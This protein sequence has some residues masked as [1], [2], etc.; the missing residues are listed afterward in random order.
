MSKEKVSILSIVVNV[1]LATSKIAV[2]VTTAST[3]IV[4]EGF[5]SLVDIFASAINF[6]GIKVARKPSDE[7][8]PYGHEK[9]EILSALVITLILFGTGAGIIYESYRQFLEPAPATLSAMAFGV[10]IVSAVANGI[11]A[12]VKI[13]CGQ[14][15]NSLSLISDGFHSRVDV[16]TSVAVIGGLAL[17]SYWLYADPLFALLVGI[18]IIKE[19]FSLGR[20]AV[21]SLLDVSAGQEVEDAVHSVAAQQNI[22]ISELKTQKRG[23]SITANLE[24][25]LPRDLK[26]DDA[27]HT[28][29]RLRESLLSQVDNLKYVAIQIRSHDITTSFYKPSY[30]RGFGWQHKGRFQDGVKSAAGKGPGGECRCPQCDYKT[31]HEP[32]VPCANSKCPKCDIALERS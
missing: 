1:L 7:K 25:S 23:S 3:L 19:S 30:G 5:H 14:R 22:D 15:E 28:A 21:D 2:G 12:R 17:S 29:D 8:H 6:I 4:A 20:E 32:G 16:Y 18:Y 13:S 10:M 11:M 31:S 9:F 24:I 27:T 26:V